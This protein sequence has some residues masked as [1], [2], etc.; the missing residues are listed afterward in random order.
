M[1]E[2][3][4]EVLDLLRMQDTPE[5]VT[6]SELLELVRKS[7]VPM[8]PR[9]LTY[10]VTE[11]LVPKSLR[12]GA[13]AGA[14][15]RKVVDLVTF[16]AW[17]RQVGF[18][19]EA[20][21]KV[22]PVWI[23]VEQSKASK[24][25]DLRRLQEFAEGMS[26]DEE[27]VLFVETLQG[28]RTCPVC[29]PGHPVAVDE[30]VDRKGKIQKVSQEKGFEL[31]IGKVNDEGDVHP[32]RILQL[33][34]PKID[35]R[36]LVTLGGKPREGFKVHQARTVPARRKKAEQTAQEAATHSRHEGDRSA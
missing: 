30:I 16:I 27:Q 10:Y 35:E 20:I 34:E 13:R 28:L 18:P 6:V 14:Y 7:D 33:R 17:A 1:N 21:K 12:I 26:S 25:L 31:P 19:I 4:Q 9:T 3:D 2:S 15:P 24:R 8:S 22:R 36:T 23:F 11:G 32:F 5:M 29:Y